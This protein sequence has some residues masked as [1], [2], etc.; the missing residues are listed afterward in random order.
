M[1]CIPTSAA[2]RSFESG[3]DGCAEPDQMEQG[4]RVAVK[5]ADRDA[6]YNDAVMT[7]VD[8]SRPGRADTVTGKVAL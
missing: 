1:N 5:G 6:P 3:L 7:A 2:C 4:Q 8:C